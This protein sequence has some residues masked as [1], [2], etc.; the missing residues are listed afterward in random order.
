MI[1]SAY[2]TIPTDPLKG[3]ACPLSKEQGMKYD[4][5]KPRWELL[6]YDAV[7]EVVDVLTFGAQKYSDRNWEH[8]ILYSRVIGAAIRHLSS[9][10]QGVREDEE[11]G[12]SPLAHSACEVLFALAFEKRGMG[13]EWDNLK[14]IW[15][16]PDDIIVAQASPRNSVL[17]AGPQPGR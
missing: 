16:P 6:P 13:P 3:G 15:L 1:V 17:P 8:G 10:C 5:E 14:P 4:S 7:E 12:L 11:T 2:S 9:F